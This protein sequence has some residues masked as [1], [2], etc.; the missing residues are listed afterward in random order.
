MLFLAQVIVNGLT[1]GSLYALMALALASIFRATGMVNFAQGEMM[2]IGAMTALTAYRTFHLSY[3]PTL[4]IAVACTW[5]LGA[6]IERISRPLLNAPAFTIVLSTAAVGQIIRSG[7]RVV[8]GDELA[9]LP[10]ILSNQPFTVAGVSFTPL[11]IG[12]VVISLLCL[13]VFVAFFRWTKMGWA[14]WAT[15]QNRE[16]AALVG[17]SVPRVFSMSWGISGALAAVAGVLI[18]PLIYIT[19]D[20]GSIGV[21]G[22]MAAIIGGYNSLVGAVVG[23]FCLGLLESLAGVY[24]S[25]TFKDVVTLGVLILMVTVRPMGLLGKPETRRV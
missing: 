9:S 12:I 22:F 8:K 24:I 21:K 25:S 15:A 16:A 3:V 14:M 10:P 5:I 13:G 20:M 23:G 6:V 18:A 7:V 17:V 11:N 2:M 1:I 19:P 4:L